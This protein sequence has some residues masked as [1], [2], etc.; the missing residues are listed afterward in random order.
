MSFGWCNLMSSTSIA[1]A[2][3]LIIVFGPTAVVSN[4][5]ALTRVML[6][7][8]GVAYFEHEAE[9]AGDSELKLE[10]PLEAVDDVLKS[11]VVYDSNGG[12]GGASLPGRNPLAHAFN[13]LPFGPEAMASPAALLN[14]L[15]GVEIKV[16]SSHPIS[17][18]VLAVLPETVQLPERGT[19]TRNRVT[20]LTSSGLQQFIL[21]EAETLSFADTDLQAKVNNTLTEIAAHRG[22]GGRQITLTTR[23]SGSRVVR[24]GYVVAAPLWKA[25]FRLTLP[26]A[27]EAN[28]AHVQG[29]AVLE[30]MSGQDWHNVELTLIS[31]NPVSFRQALYQAYYVARPEVPVEVVGRVLPMPDSGALGPLKE[32]R[33]ARTEDAQRRA[34]A[35]ESR[36]TTR[37]LA[38]AGHPAP[39]A[40]PAAGLE[41]QAKAAPS[42]PVNTAEAEEAATEVVFRLPVKVTLSSGQSAIVP[43]VDRDMP[44][45]RLSLVQ[46]GNGATHPLASLRLRN[47]SKAGLP[48]GVLTLYE[49]TAAGT[50]Y[51]GDARL[52]PLPAGEDR[53]LSY[54]V[55][56]KTK[57]VREDQ[58]SN[59]IT[60]ASITQGV[61]KLTNTQRHTTVYKIAAPVTESRTLIIDHDKQHGFA[62]AQPQAAGVDE[63]ASAYR[64]TVELKSGEVK[65]V[66]VVLE[67]PELE[68]LSMGDIDEH[69]IAEVTASRGV[70][71]A[72]KKALA[73][74][75]ALRRS[76]DDKK[77]VAEQVKNDVEALLADQVR[78]RENL[79]RIDKDSSLH[80]RYMEKLTDEEAQFEALK[81]QAAKAAE[82]IRAA[83]A[84][85]DAFIAQI[86]I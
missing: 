65:R 54:A 70:D 57:I 58:Q 42:H 80:K 15:Q 33:N 23:G 4:E 67:R 78:I 74:L 7:S 84:Q 51:V 86:G 61:L 38:I 73:E 26:H 63:T 29:W 17:G 44:V 31:G 81:A 82:E 68:T 20:V 28:K 21:E 1:V 13:N 62:L 18:K 2:F 12:V 22:K 41:S 16:G 11:I 36:S 32:A 5:L 60:K 10:V 45:D 55:D 46:P 30:N 56:E 37:Q 72:I 69:K 76:L 24:V 77:A 85:V 9:V 49:E 64:L 8:G 40:A 66:V 39:P 19:L 34:L 48:P 79:G 35:E 6:S 59:A 75:E 53:L 50:A 3:V 71:P 52:T 14:A 27:G 43:I 25:S 47:D 83:T